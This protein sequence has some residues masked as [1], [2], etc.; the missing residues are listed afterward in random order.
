MQVKGVKM[1]RREAEMHSLSSS[2]ALTQLL[3]QRLCLPFFGDVGE[4][5]PENTHKTHDKQHL[6]KALKIDKKKG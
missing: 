6:D 3:Y 4:Q 5:L 1:R 2:E